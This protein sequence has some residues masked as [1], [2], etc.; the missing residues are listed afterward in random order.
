VCLSRVQ[1]VRLRGWEEFIVIQRDVDFSIDLQRRV[2][3]LHTAP[4]RDLRTLCSALLE[5]WHADK[6]M[7]PYPFPLDYESLSLVSGWRIVDE[8][9]KQ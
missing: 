1:T 7:A 8:V 4:A 3:A 6:E 2:V 5:E 9:T